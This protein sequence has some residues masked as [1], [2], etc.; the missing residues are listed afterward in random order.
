M[1]GPHPRPGIESRRMNRLL[2]VF[3]AALAL[4]SCGGGSS[5]KPEPDPAGGKTAP[6]NPADVDLEA[7]CLAASGK[8]KTLRAKYSAE[9]ATNVSLTLAVDR[10]GRAALHIEPG[11]GRVMDG[12]LL[13]ARL[14]ARDGTYRV[15]TVRIGYLLAAALAIRDGK[16]LP[17][18]SANPPVPAQH[19]VVDLELGIDER[20][21]AQ[22]NASLAVALPEMPS[23]GW[24][25]LLRPREGF[26]VRAADRTAVVSGPCGRV[27]IDRDTGS[28]V[29]WIL[30]PPGGRA[31]RL[32]RES[33]AADEP[34]DPA[35]FTLAGEPAAEVDAR[36]L[37]RESVIPLTLELTNSEKDWKRRLGRSL[38]MARAYYRAAWSAAEID[39]LASLGA[40]RRH[41]IARELQARNPDLPQ[42][43]IDAAASRT[44]LPTIGEAISA[45]I[46]Y[47]A[48]VFVQLAQPVDGEGEREF[49][50]GFMEV[51]NDEILQPALDAGKGK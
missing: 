36:S 8:W 27:A 11:M 29:E 35:L 37:S 18:S 47:D 16:P 51:V 30:E 38:G 22:R 28:L 43:D 9:G 39:R 23:F 41:E 5:T 14:Q 46:S 24:L 15:A 7:E 17:E 42:A 1:A 21:K 31:A 2:A 25:L 3:L 26:T 4:C 49:Q 45:E 40:A 20:G 12:G 34:L 50:S 44:A 10:S 6:E 13:S 32:R 19:L 33:F 48:Q